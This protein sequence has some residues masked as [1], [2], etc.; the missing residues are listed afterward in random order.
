MYATPLILDLYSDGHKDVIVPTFVHYL[1]VPPTTWLGYL[2]L[3]LCGCALASL[4]N[5]PR[6]RTL[7][8]S[9]HAINAPKPLQHTHMASTLACS[10]QSYSLLP[11]SPLVHLDG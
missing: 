11:R 6:L 5:I 2:V 4:P 1:E 9:A 8:G 10:M 3:P 7:Q